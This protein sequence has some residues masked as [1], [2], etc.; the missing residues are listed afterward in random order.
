[1]PGTDCEVALGLEVAKTSTGLDKEQPIGA[2]VCFL[3]TGEV[4]G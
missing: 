1:M 4:T 2:Q 3:Q